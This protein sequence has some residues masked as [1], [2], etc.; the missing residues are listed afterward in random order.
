MLDFVI[1]YYYRKNLITSLLHLTE[2]NQPVIKFKYWVYLLFVAIAF[3]LKPALH[4][5]AKIIEDLLF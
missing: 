4:F 5:V 2:H 3:L 1:L